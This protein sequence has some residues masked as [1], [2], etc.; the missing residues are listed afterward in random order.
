MA[1]VERL[2]A[3]LEDRAW[4]VAHLH[5]IKLIAVVWLVFMLSWI[6]G[7]PEDEEF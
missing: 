7:T 2:I 4:S 6:F 5:C 1:E 3:Q